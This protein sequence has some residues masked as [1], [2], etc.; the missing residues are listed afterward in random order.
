MVET[1]QPATIVTAQPPVEDPAVRVLRVVREHRA[2]LFPEIASRT[3]L[4]I[5]VLSDAVRE[6]A[7]KNMV[8]LYAPDDPSNLVIGVSRSYR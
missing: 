4:R 8:K 3:G 1:K 2:L 7:S 5:S 6:L